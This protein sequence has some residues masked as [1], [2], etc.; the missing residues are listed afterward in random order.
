MLLILITLQILSIVFSQQSIALP[1]YPSCS[2]TLCK[3]GYRCVEGKGCVQN[4]NSSCSF[5]F[6]PPGQKC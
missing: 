4:P 6:C 5:V 1:R 2:V 3:N